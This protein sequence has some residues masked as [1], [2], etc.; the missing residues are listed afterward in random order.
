MARSKK[1]L[2]SLPED[3]LKEIDALAAKEHRSRSE[4]IRE[5]T[6]RY[7]TERG[8]GER[9]IDDPVVRDAVRSMEE[10]TGI[11]SLDH[12]AVKTVRSMRDARHRRSPGK[13]KA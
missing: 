7:I 2:F 4:L 13:P 8:A 12:D 11:I 10:V 1:I 5:A 6:R 3:F 9:P